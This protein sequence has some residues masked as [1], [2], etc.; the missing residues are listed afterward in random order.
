M[1][2]SCIKRARTLPVLPSGSWI[3]LPRPDLAQGY[4]RQVV[5]P[6]LR[7]R[8]NGYGVTL[9]FVSYKKQEPKPNGLGSTDDSNGLFQEIFNYQRSRLPPTPLSPR[10]EPPRDS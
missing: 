6:T 9:P 10:P 7:H 2:D 1:F 5:R 3:T 4:P 8:K